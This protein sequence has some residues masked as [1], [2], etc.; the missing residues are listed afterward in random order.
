M[1]LP[2]TPPRR[3]TAVEDDEDVCA[4]VQQNGPAE[5]QEISLA[6]EAISALIAFFRTLDDWDRQAKQQ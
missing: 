2:A 6:P 3:C 1:S 5:S 4:R